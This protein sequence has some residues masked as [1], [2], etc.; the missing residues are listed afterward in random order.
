MAEFGGHEHECPS[1]GVDGVRLFEIEIGE[2]VA[3]EGRG[4]GKEFAQ[5]R[6]MAESVPGGGKPSMTAVIELVVLKEDF[7]GGSP[8]GGIRCEV[9]KDG[10][11]GADW[12][13]GVGIEEEGVWGLYILDG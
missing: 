13:G 2:V 8:D 3:G 7:A 6:K 1:E 10:G 11:N 4:V 12:D 5:P 9:V